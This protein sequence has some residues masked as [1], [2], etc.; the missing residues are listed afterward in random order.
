VWPSTGWSTPAAE[1]V[2]I[3]RLD[4]GELVVAQTFAG[5]H[6]LRSPLLPGFALDVDDV[7]GS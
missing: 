4:N 6:T 2:W 7:F 5:R 3:H 1:T